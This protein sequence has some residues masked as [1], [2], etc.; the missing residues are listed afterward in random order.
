MKI[1]EFN[2]IV[3]STTNFKESSKILN[4]LTDKYGLIGI[5]AKGA[6]NIKSK[7]RSAANP[8][9][10]G[11]IN[12]YYKEDKLS[13]LISLDVI[14]SFSNIQKD[15][16]KI[17]YANYLLDL[18]LQVS[19][20]ANDSDLFDLLINALIKIEDGL[21]PRII[22]QIVELKLLDYLGVSPKL[23]SCA[24]CGS[25]NNIVNLSSFHGGYLCSNCIEDNMNFVDSKTIRVIRQYYYVDISKITKLDIKDITIKQI[26]EFLDDYYDRYTGLYLKSKSFLKQIQK[27]N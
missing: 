15:L 7:L 26:D 25:Q 19:R 5:M 9:A 8:L 10:Y 24:I 14:N 4:V 16:E 12:A 21:N 3:L 2:G 18:F 1:E 6:R 27:L 13:T 17:S 11:T 20:Q 23:D 22:T